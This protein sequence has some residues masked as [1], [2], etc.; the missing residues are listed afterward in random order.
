MSITSISDIGFLSPSVKFCCLSLSRP[1]YLSPSLSLSHI[2]H[3][4]FSPSP[5]T[6]PNW[7]YFGLSCTRTLNSACLFSFVAFCWL[8]AMAARSSVSDKR[9]IVYTSGERPIHV[10][11]HYSKVRG[12]LSRQCFRLPLLSNHDFLLLLALSLSRSVSFR[13]VLTS[14]FPYESLARSQLVRVNVCACVYKYAYSSS[15]HVTHACIPLLSHCF[16]F[17]Y[18]NTRTNAYS[19][20]HVAEHTHTRTCTVHAAQY[21]ICS[22]FRC[23]LRSVAHRIKSFTSHEC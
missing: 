12:D 11:L 16:W 1:L 15:K 7:P 2:F 3:L 13:L 14:R 19:H 8:D 4:R 20:I 5:S 21:T 17:R 18:S 22:T 10:L 23:S 6:F 9:L